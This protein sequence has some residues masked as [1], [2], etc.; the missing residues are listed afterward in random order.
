M[1]FWRV[2]A[3]MADEV[4]EGSDADSIQG[5][6]GFQCRKLMRFRMVPVRIADR[7]AEVS[8]A[9]SRQSSGGLRYNS[10]IFQAVGDNT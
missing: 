7:V 10:K 3:Q 5:S 9:H 8:S 6:G 4:S 2:W 1:R